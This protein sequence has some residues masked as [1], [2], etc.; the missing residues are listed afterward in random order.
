MS[1]A[2]SDRVYSVC[3]NIKLYLLTLYVSS[4]DVKPSEEEV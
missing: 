1:T 2:Q 4:T 3:T